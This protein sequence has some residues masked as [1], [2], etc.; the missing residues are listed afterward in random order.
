MTEHILTAIL[1]L[2]FPNRGSNIL[3]TLFNYLVASFMLL[4]WTVTFVSRAYCDTATLLLFGV[5]GILFNKCWTVW[6]LTG[7]PGGLCRDG[8]LLDLELL[9][10]FVK[11]LL[12]G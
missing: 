3:M 6:E 12:L 8:S 2:H 4:E 1:I 5:D 11:Y 10:T 7:H 9:W